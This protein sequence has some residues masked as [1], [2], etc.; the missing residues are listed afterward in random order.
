MSDIITLAPLK[1]SEEDEDGCKGIYVLD[2]TGKTI[3]ISSDVFNGYSPRNALIK[4]RGIIDVYEVLGK[5]Y[6][7]KEAFEYVQNN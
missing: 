4:K 5:W 7:V 2:V 3:E 6:Y 1:L